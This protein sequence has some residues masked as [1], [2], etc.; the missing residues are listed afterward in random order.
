MCK[1]KK[2]HLNPVLHLYH[3]H[4][5]CMLACNFS[6]IRFIAPEI[7][8]LPFFSPLILSPLP[9]MLLLF[10]VLFEMSSF[11][12]HPLLCYVLMPVVIFFFSFPPHHGHYDC[13]PYCCCNFPIFFLFFWT[14]LHSFCFSF[15]SWTLFYMFCCGICGSFFLFALFHFLFRAVV[16]SAEVRSPQR[17]GPALHVEAVDN[18]LR[19]LRPPA[20]MLHTLL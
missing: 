13:S 14:L 18:C 20:P 7:N 11:Y 19:P 17:R 10:V 1:R 15:P 12:L 5:I 4:V 8:P 3:K 9:D 2:Q 6:C 16:Q